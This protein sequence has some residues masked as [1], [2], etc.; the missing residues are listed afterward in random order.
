MGKVDMQW[1]WDITHYCICCRCTNLT[2]PSKHNTFP[3]IGIMH[4]ARSTNAKILKCIR[5]LVTIIY[6][7]ISNNHFPIIC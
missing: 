3:Q 1:C 5:L 2:K 7:K 4:I 6:N